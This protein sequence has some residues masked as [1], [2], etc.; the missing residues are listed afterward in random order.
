MAGYEVC[1]FVFLARRLGKEG[2]VI[3]LILNPDFA[4]GF[5][6]RHCKPQR[7]AQL[8][9]FCYGSFRGGKG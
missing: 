6:V 1:A 8:E 7:N 4:V 9:R 3:F 5:V 2:D